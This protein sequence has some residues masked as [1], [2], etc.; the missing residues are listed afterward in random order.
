MP[1]S[2]ALL[3]WVE[4]VL[5]AVSASLFLLTLFSRRW[6]EAILGADPD[7]GNGSLE[8]AIPLLLLT[9]AITLSICARREWRTQRS[10]GASSL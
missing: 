8:F 9:C 4:T 6:I 7:R 1:H 5:A 2:K 3:A 10:I